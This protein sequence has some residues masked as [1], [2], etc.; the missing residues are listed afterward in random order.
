MGIAASGNILANM[1]GPPAGGYV[2]SHLGLR[3]TFFLSGSL[4]LVAVVF[5][6]FVFIDMRGSQSPS[7]KSE[8]VEEAQPATES[9]NE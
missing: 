6:W 3:E 5:L 2:A 4:L 7:K 8:D 9:V 1:I